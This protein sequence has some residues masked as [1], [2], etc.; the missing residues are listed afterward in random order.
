MYGE[1]KGDKMLIVNFLGT[2]L[3]YTPLPSR[4][5]HT[6]ECNHHIERAEAEQTRSNNTLQFGVEVGSG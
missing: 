5:T 1:R 4:I 3:F 6:H 2:S